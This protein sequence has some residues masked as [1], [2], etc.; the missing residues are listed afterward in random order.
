MVLL[1]YKLSMRQP[2]WYDIFG[3]TLQNI[4]WY[5]AERWLNRTFGEKE[6]WG[7][8]IMNKILDDKE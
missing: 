7:E 2:R 8:W 3:N 4:E 5:F 6:Y 1:G